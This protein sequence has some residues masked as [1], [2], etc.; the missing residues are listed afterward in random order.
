MSQPQETRVFCLLSP[1]RFGW[2]RLRGKTF[3]F[4]PMDHVKKVL[5]EVEKGAHSVWTDT[6]SSQGVAQDWR[7]SL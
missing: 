3:H 6:S 2:A 5:Y 4:S 7:G 1:F